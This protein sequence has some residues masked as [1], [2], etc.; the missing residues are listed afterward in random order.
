MAPISIVII[1]DHPILRQ[2]LVDIFAGYD[3][4]AVV[5]SGACGA[6]AVAIA[7]QQSPD[8]LVIDLVMPGNALE[9]IAR[10]RMKSASMVIIVFTAS[11]RVDHAINALE[12]GA[13]GYVLKGSTANELR[14]AIVSAIQGETFV[15]PGLASKMITVLRRPS[16][17]K[18]CGAHL[19]VREEQVARLLMHGC[20]NKSIAD[21]LNLS[22]KTVKHYMTLLMH[23]LD[24]HNRVE[25]VLAVQKWDQKNYDN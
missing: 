2:G 17:S 15:T 8:V 22:E 6:D 14:G 24:A 18:G 7:Q 11:D 3:D 13:N 19:S 20:S 4:Y 23:K 16:A 5:G 1:D 25:V 12:A 10:I 21:R 9:A